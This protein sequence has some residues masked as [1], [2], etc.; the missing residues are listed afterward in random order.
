MS[1]C[2]YALAAIATAFAWF[3]GL[4]SPSNVR[5]NRFV[6]SMALAA[7]MASAP[8]VDRYHDP[9]FEPKLTTVALHVNTYR[10]VLAR[11]DA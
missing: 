1:A 2:V 8:A 9:R 6:V 10:E 5:H 3:V 11:W 7:V 4:R